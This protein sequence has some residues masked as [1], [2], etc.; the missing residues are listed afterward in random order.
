MFPGKAAFLRRFDVKSCQ[1][2]SM[3]D[4]TFPVRFP[5][6]SREG[7]T[8][9]IPGAGNELVINMQKTVGNLV[10]RVLKVD[11]GL[12]KITEDRVEL[13]IEMSVKEALE[14]LL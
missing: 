3:K 13:R 8:V 2:M 9:V 10:V 4:E 6:G 11:S 12:F 5:P 1:L 7:F 14:V